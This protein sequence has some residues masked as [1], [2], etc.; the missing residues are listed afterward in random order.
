MGTEGKTK[1]SNFSDPITD[2]IGERIQDLLV[3]KGLSKYRLAQR[4]GLSLICITRYIDGTR[5]PTITSLQRMCDGFEITLSQF[6]E[7]VGYHKDSKLSDDQNHLLAMW[8][9]MDEKRRESMLSYGEFLI[10]GDRTEH[11]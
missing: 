4:S 8:E 11:E 3:R 2:Y 1:E 9:E 5:T 7:G 6:F 10:H